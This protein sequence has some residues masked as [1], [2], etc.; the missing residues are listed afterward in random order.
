MRYASIRKMDISNG[1]GIGV[2]LFVQGCPFHCKGCFNQETWDFDGGK[3]WTEEIEN[4]FLNLIGQR[5]V[6]RVSILGG[7]PLCEENANEV[8]RLIIKIKML[9]PDVEIWV[10]TG[11]NI[12]IANKMLGEDAMNSISYIKTGVYRQE[13]KCDDNIQYGLR[14]ATKNQAVYKIEPRGE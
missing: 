3:E 14:L 9:Y 11:Y 6:K 1:S 5:F 2:S 7:E 12:M 10:F 4:A 8:A 13:E